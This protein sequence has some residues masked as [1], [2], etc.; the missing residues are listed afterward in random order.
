[1]EWGQLSQWAMAAATLIGVGITV[2]CTILGFL[3]REIKVTRT[4]SSNG[5]A[6]L[7]ERLDHLPEQVVS[8]R[9]Y[10][11]TI[12]GLEHIIQGLENTISQLSRMIQT[13]SDQFDHIQFEYA[14]G[15]IELLRHQTDCPARSA[16]AHRPKAAAT[17]HRGEI[18]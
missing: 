8:R 1:M 3:F 5:R 18:L 7:H 14:D 4:E 6:R 2:L 13:L 9:E 16:A 12:K 10:E 17:K 11:A 15:R